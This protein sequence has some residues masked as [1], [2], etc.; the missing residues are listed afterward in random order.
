MTI[1][2]TGTPIAMSEINAEFG[3]GTNLNSYRGHQWYTD[4]GS[5]GNFSSGAI[6]MYDFYGK[7]FNVEYFIVG[8]GAGGSA[9]TSI[10]SF[11]KYGNPYTSLYTYGGMGG[12][13]GHVASGTMSIQIGGSYN[14]YVGAGGHGSSTSGPFFGGDGEA[15]SFN[16]ASAPGGTG[17]T[18]YSGSYYNGGSTFS[19]FMLPGLYYFGG[20]VSGAWSSF[21]RMAA[22]GPYNVYDNTQTIYFHADGT[23]QLAITCDDY[24]FITIDGQGP[25]TSAGFNGGPAVYDM[26]ISRGYHNVRVYAD[27]RGGYQNGVSFWLCALGEVTD[28]ATA[29]TVFGADGLDGLYNPAGKV[30]DNGTGQ[31]GYGAGYG[32][33]GGGGAGGC[34][35]VAIRYDG[36]T[37]L[38]SGGNSIYYANGKMHHLF[39][40]QGAHTL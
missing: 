32:G 18:S 5:S 26:Y 22:N 9:G 4:G 35:I 19:S 27:N 29:G 25:F 11:D 40:V 3:L 37:Q 36:S 20:S 6:T 33:A 10:V 38:F 14:V 39:N 31:G 12:G 30:G 8:G 13:G 24:A 15:S 16:V 1:H 28:F 7:R 17:I 23:H 34:G 2:G 21:Q